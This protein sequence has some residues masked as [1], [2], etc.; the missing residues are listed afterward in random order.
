MTFSTLSLGILLLIK[1]PRSL[2]QF[3]QKKLL[4][5]F[6]SGT[7]LAFHF[8]SWITS[9]EYTSVASSVVLVTTTPIWVALFSFFI[10]KESIGK[11]LILGLVF[12]VIGGIITASN[13][14]CSFQAGQLLCTPLTGL[15]SSRSMLGNGLALLGAWAAAGYMLIGRKLRAN[16]DI[17]PYSFVVY[18]FSA[19]LLDLTVII[20]GENLYLYSSQTW[21][22]LL[23]LALIPQ[24]LGHTIFNWSL[25]FL[26]AT[27]V[28]TALLGEPIGSTIIAYFL[29]KETP[30]L[31]EIV[32]SVFILTGITLAA[33]S[34]RSPS[35]V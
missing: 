17:L 27:I 35:G 31:I 14:I 8:A 7:L 29:L 22:I 15:F 2:N 30:T 13:E 11:K 18:G 34:K 26:P 12:A 16:T 28:S 32:G 19:I 21:I 9:L 23:L 24:L 3:T 33:V 10:L 1:N 6:L 20:R 25:K 5:A 4:L